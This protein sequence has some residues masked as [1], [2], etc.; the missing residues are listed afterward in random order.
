MALNDIYILEDKQTWNS[1]EEVLNVYQYQRLAPEG[2]AADCIQ[3]FE[4]SMLTAIRA[5]QI[6]L[7]NHALLRCYNLGDLEDFAELT[8]SGQ[9]GVNSGEALPVFA[10]VNFTLRP[11]SRAIRPGAK[12]IAGIPENVTANGVITNSTYLASMETL[13][14]K[15]F[16]NIQDTPSETEYQPVIVKRI[17]YTTSGGTEAYRFPEPG[18]T[19]V[20]SPVTGCL[21]N[22]NVSHQVSRGNGR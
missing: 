17:K 18:D 1:G 3:A 21:V 15:M 2:T 13:R 20:V 8:L 16:T 10:A 7:V 5:L 12:R 14:V 19:L 6:N 22:I 4:Q 11:G 9:A